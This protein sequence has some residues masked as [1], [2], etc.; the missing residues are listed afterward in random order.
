MKIWKRYRAGGG[1][2]FLAIEDLNT[3]S[4]R[5]IRE[6]DYD[7]VIISLKPEMT[8]DPHNDQHG[9]KIGQTMINGESY[10]FD[11][12]MIKIKLHVLLW[13]TMI[14]LGLFGTKTREDSL[15]R[16]VWGG[17]FGFMSNFLIVRFFDIILISR[18]FLV[19]L[20]NWVKT[21]LEPKKPD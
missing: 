8:Y 15:T 20:A 21:H 3:V 2:F 16:I 12:S 14:N 17:T 19:K 18:T 4:F 9:F 6:S 1:G 5:I 10:L 7:P 11:S 13:Q